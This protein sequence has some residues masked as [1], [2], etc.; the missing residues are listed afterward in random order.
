MKRRG[1]I[2]GKIWEILFWG[3]SLSQAFSRTGWTLIIAQE[4]EEKADGCSYGPAS[5]P[6]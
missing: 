2:L 1:R 4:V 5:R 6:L 3:G